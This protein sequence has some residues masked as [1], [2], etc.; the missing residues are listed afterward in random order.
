MTTFN[1][2]TAPR[3]LASVLIA[4]A[5]G[6]ASTP[7]VQDGG[8]APSRIDAARAAQE[9]RAETIRLISEE[10][11]AWITGKAILE[12]SIELVDQEIEGLRSS[13]VESRTAFTDTQAKVAELEAESARLGASLADLGGTIGAAEAR[14]KEL[15]ALLP[16]PI[17]ERVE[18]L[19]KR[20]PADPSDTKLQLRDRFATVVAIVNEIDKFNREVTV[21]SE[22]RRA[23]VEGE[24]GVAVTTLYFG[25]GQAYCA[26]AD[27]TQAWVG[28]VGEAGWT[29]VAQDE[30]AAAIGQAIDVAEGAATAAFVSLPTKIK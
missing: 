24:A 20:I 28:T 15:L 18:G 19:T 2:L 16:E 8:D 5:V 9:Q 25:I 30:H 27:R 22:I 11:A 21:R 1:T 29:W 4:G 17:T 26:N 23:P 12:D 6:F 3:L 7:L 13:I 10:R 14:L